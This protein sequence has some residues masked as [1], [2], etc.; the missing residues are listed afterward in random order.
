VWRLYPEVTEVLE[1]LAA[2]AE[3]GVIT[4][5]DGRFRAIADELGITRYFRHTVISSE[6]GAD[7]PDRVIFQRAVEMAGV[8]PGEALHAGDDPVCDWQGAADAGLQVFRL[9]RPR[10]SLRDLLGTV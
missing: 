5:F 4:N 10:N 2:R 7:K 6:V 8:S 1:A 3:L 9:D